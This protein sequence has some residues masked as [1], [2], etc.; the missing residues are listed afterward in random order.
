MHTN[1]DNSRN[2]EKSS[3]KQGTIL[4][5]HWL[6]TR[7]CS[8]DVQ[9]ERST[10]LMQTLQWRASDEHGQNP[11]S[12]FRSPSH[13]P[14]VPAARLRFRLQRRHA[15]APVEYGS[16]IVD[17]QRGVEH[18]SPGNRLIDGCADDTTHTGDDDHHPDR[19][20]FCVQQRAEQQ[21]FP[22]GQYRGRTRWLSSS[23]NDG[24][25]WRQWR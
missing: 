22:Y 6:A 7:P 9:L 23:D 12:S 1:S 25:E 14:Y 11:A 18:R 15:T 5:S 24:V 2:L 13:Q 3:T 4:S 21:R 16:R 10:F 17:E 8:R 19:R 20:E